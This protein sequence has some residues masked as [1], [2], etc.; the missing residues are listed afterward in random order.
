[1]LS[2]EKKEN[3]TEINIS[4][5]KV[6]DYILLGVLTSSHYNIKY[7]YKSDSSQ[8]FINLGEYKYSNYIPI[9]ITKNDSSLLLY[10]EYPKTSNDVFEFRIV[11]E[12]TIEIDSDFNSTNKGP[13]YIILNYYKI[14]GLKSFVIKSNKNFQFYEQELNKEISMS[15]EKINNI[16]IGNQNLIFLMY[17]KEQLF[18]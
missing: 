3:F 16:F 12:D 7:K 10:I 1:M 5:Y 17:I 4:N 18:I 11:K 8:D 13:K 2:E 14:N 9:Q 15:I 6:G